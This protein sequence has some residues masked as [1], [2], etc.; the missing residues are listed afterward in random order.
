LAIALAYKRSRDAIARHVEE[1]HQCEYKA[2]EALLEGGRGMRPPSE[3]QP[4]AI[5]VNEAGM[6]SLILGSKLEAAKAFKNWICEEVLP[7][8]RKH[9][10]YICPH[11]EVHNELQLH[12]AIS[13]HWH[14]HHPGVRVS[15][16]LGE[17]QLIKL[18]TTEPV[19]LVDPYNQLNG[20]KIKNEFGGIVHIGLRKACAYKGYQGGQPDL[21]I[22]QRSGNFSDQALELKTPEG[23]GVVTPKQQKWLEDLRLAGYQARVCDNLEDAIGF[24]ARFLRNAR[25]CCLHCGSSF[26]SRKNLERHLERMRP[27]GI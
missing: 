21:I 19:M 27:D 23:D 1:K 11:V 25:V 15:P 3:M 12:N 17:Y 20:V 16:G 24:I 14:K 8:I 18:K 10:R 9:G 5:W 4:Q 26:K 6:Y 13:E 7:S 22:H 2:L